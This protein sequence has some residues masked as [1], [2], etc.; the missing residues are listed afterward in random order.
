MTQ[1]KFVTK[2]EKSNLQVGRFFKRYTVIIIGIVLLILSPFVGAASLINPEL[3][4]IA[5]LLP[6]IGILLI[7]AGAF[8]AY[9]VIMNE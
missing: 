2:K 8:V 5:S 3:E 6:I 9:L 4:I 1:S 7:F